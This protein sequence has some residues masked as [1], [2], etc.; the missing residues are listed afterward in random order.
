MAR[1]ARTYQSKPIYSP[2][3]RTKA[4][5]VIPCLNTQKSIADIVSRARK[6]VDEVIVVDDGSID[7]TAEVAKAA[8]ALIINRR[9]N[10]G[11][12]A[13]MKTA[14]E[15]T[16][17]DIVV[18]IDG[19]GQ[20]DPEY[21]PALLEPIIQGKADFVIGSRYLKGSQLSANPF[22]RKAAN[23]LASFVISF[24]ISI[25]QP[26]ARIVSR[27]PLA[28]KA[29]GGKL[30]SDSRVINNS[31][32]KTDNYRLLN[33]KLKWI[34]DCTSG[35]T[36]VRKSNWSKL[37]LVSDRFQI[38]TEMIF[39]QARNGFI[40]AETPI[41]CKWGTCLSQLSIIKDSLSTLLLLAKK[42]NQYFK[43]PRL[44]SSASPDLNRSSQREDS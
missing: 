37:N 39:E 26:L 11:K 8:G 13:A 20:H 5:A 36:A 27:H 44:I 25:A 41:S 28:E 18:F 1:P 40:I 16:D 17:A 21:I 43:N 33:G 22:T 4:V 29:S 24:V 38:E 19:D 2:V 14:I 3:A 30:T 23:V 35:F 10:Y 6:Y 32:H 12:G 15:N 9:K 31:R 7:K 34:S 42:L